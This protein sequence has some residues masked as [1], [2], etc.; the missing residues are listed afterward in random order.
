MLILQDI[1]C[2][3]L[4]MDG[5]TPEPTSTYCWEPFRHTSSIYFEEIGLM[6]Q[7]ESEL[8]IKLDV[9]ALRTRFEQLQEYLKNTKKR[10]EK[11]IAG[12]AQQI[13]AQ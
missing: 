7:A 3:E 2:V 11:V 13:C 10:C 12:N 5:T 8:V 9:T 1:T 4:H 6:N